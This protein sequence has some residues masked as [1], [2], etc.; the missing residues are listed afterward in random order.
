MFGVSRY[1][2]RDAGVRGSIAVDVWLH[3]WSSVRIKRMF[4]G[5]ASLLSAPSNRIA[6]PPK[7][8]ADTLRRK[9]LRLIISPLA[10]SRTDG[11]YSE[12]L[13]CPSGLPPPALLTV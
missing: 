4:G 10:V 9:S 11:Q 7:A 12:F 2:D 13:G 5:A 1:V 6:V 8:R 3:P